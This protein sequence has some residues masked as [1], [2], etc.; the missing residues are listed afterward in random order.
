MNARE[1]LMD[2]HSRR[3]EVRRLCRTVLVAE[4]DAAET[5]AMI[6]LGRL[7]VGIR[8]YSD[9]PQPAR[10]KRAWWVVLAYWERWRP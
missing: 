9:P 10:W 8:L 2:V 3:E 1:P 6:L 4:T 5:N 7:F